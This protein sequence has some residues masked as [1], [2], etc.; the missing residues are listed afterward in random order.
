MMRILLA[1]DDDM[2]RDMLSRRLKKKGYTVIAVEDGEKA[3]AASKE[4]QPD[5][6]LMDLDIPVMD[7]WEATA[8]IKDDA[9]TSAIPIIAVTSYAMASDRDRALGAGCDDYE[10]KPFDLLRLLSKIEALIGRDG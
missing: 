7:G 6:I 1:E 3:V 10:S 4:H 8:M 5:I 2:S 9:S